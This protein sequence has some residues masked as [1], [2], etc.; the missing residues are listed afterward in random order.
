MRAASLGLTNSGAAADTKPTAAKWKQPARA[1]SKDAPTTTVEPPTTIKT[2]TTTV[3]PP[4]TIK[5]PTTVE[6][7][8]T[9]KTPTT[10]EPPVAP[11]TA[12][13]TFGQPGPS[14]I[15]IN[16]ASVLRLGASLLLNI[17][18]WFLAAKLA[19][20]QQALVEE[21][22]RKKIDPQVEKG[23]EKLA[24][25]AERLYFEN[26]VAPVYLQNTIRVEWYQMVSFYSGDIT[27][28]F[29]DV[30]H[31]GPVTT[32]RENVAK[33]TIED[34]DTKFP[35]RGI[36]ATH[37]TSLVTY[38][39]PIEFNEP[40]AQREARVMAYQAV[41]DAE[42][43][44]SVRR[45]AATY[46]R[47]SANDPGDNE[48]K[49]DRDAGIKSWQLRWTRAFLAYTKGR[50]HLKELHIDALRYLD[51]LEGRANPARGTAVNPQLDPF[52]RRQLQ[53]WMRGS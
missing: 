38:S 49:A 36:Q 43:G 8:T 34:H 50:A 51:E 33:D 9:I 7:P 6:P 47:M 18:L 29:T 10:V 44:H 52:E 42:A 45:R 23:L 22:F 37:F 4:T 32:S 17:A 26:P 3:E 19:K 53:E 35:E 27:M 5:T 14:V 48:R 46:R 15:T 20:W 12:K 24:P 16:R 21:R 40:A 31:V 39:L 41:Q 13:P 30:E 28:G 1:P 2:P 25:E 11:V